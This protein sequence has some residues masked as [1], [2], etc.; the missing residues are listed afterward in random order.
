MKVIPLIE[1]V[2]FDCDGVLVDS[3]MLA[4]QIM[5][6]AL[7]EAGLSL[8]PHQCLSAFVGL[9]AAAT[10]RKI[11]FDYDI[12]LTVEFDRLVVERL[13]HAFHRRLKTLPGVED[14]IRSLRQPYCVASN[15]SHDRL[16]KTFAATGLTPLV[17]GR[18][19]SA[20]DVAHGKP[21]PDLFLH[22]A[23]TMG[24]IAP[25]NCLVIEDSVTGVTAARAAGMHVIGYCG[26]S[27]ILPGHADRL[28]SLGVD[29]ILTDHRDVTH[30]QMLTPAGPI[31]APA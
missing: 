16:R 25:Q 20:N 15:S 6:E 10:R 24:N 1:L 30:L 28:L 31:P 4:A 23:R 29:H 9:D 5:S 13:N 22:A 19:F 14:L 12:V 8:D 27:H 26:G 18:I 2:I 11:Q 17:E 21:A 3:E 7:G